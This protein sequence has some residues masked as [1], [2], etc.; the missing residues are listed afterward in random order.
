MGLGKKIIVVGISV[1]FG[2]CLVLTTPIGNPA[3]IAGVCLVVIPMCVPKFL[4]AYTE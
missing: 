3:F 4:F 1:I 2:A